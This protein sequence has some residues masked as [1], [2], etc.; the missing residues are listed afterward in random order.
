MIDQSLVPQSIFVGKLRNKHDS[1]D[2]SY[3]SSKCSM[4]P[5][6]R[7]GVTNLVP[8][9]I[10]KTAFSLKTHS[11]HGTGI[12]IYEHETHKNQ[13]VPCR[14]SK[15]TYQSHG[16]GMG[17]IIYRFSTR[18]FQRHGSSHGFLWRINPPVDQLI[19]PKSSPF[20]PQACMYATS[21][22]CR[23]FG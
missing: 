19:N 1:P 23:P 2:F 8:T 18:F 17:Y 7:F 20:I 6:G 12:Y 22:G 5:H 16:N 13:P 10:L 9:K 3:V 21:N 11:I 15:Y 4:N 14:V